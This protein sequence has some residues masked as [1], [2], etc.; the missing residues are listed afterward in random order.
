VQSNFSVAEEN[1]IKAVYHLQQTSDTVTTNALA[2][3]L[4]ATAASVTD[5]LKKLKTK[6]LLNY[7]KYQ[8]FQLT[9]EGKK[10]ALVIIRKHRL[11]EYF[12]VE[13]LQFGWDEVHEVAEQLE[14][15]NSK[16]LIDKLDAF[17][18]FPKYDPHG[19]PIPDI[20]GKM[21]AQLQ[22]NLI[23]LPINKPAEVSSV[24]S[25][26]SELLDLLKHKNI[27]IGTKI[28]VKRKF[29]FDHSI[30]IKVKNNPP[31]TISQQLAQALFVKT[32]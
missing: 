6:K 2:A 7:E 9:T 19:D 10:L 29:S 13:K 31:I 15:V 21:S 5:M 8:G 16:K 30:E 4:K 20:N 18:N 27:G 32:L 11:W 23:D 22:I 1:Y 12:L 26:S 24:G 14:H 28:E 25:Q 3:E 17:L